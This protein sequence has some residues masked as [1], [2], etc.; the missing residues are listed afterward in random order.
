MYVRPKNTHPRI[1]LKSLCLDQKLKYVFRY[2]GNE[3][4]GSRKGDVNA[5]LVDLG[6]QGHGGNSRHSARGDVGGVTIHMTMLVL[7]VG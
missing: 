2:S 5:D 6:G 7:S 3:Q 1:W 4:V